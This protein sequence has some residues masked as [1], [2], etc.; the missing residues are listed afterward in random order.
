MAEADL[1]SDLLV[2][3]VDSVQTNKNIEAFYK[4]YEDKQGNIEEIEKRF[5]RIMS[6]I[7]SIYKADEIKNTNWSRIH[8][9][10]TLFTSLSNMVYG[11]KGLKPVTKKAINEKS[12]GK[13]R[14]ALDNLS[15]QYDM[16]ALDID[17]PEYPQDFKQFIYYSRRGTTDTAARVF[18][19]NF[20]CKKLKNIL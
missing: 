4:E 1:T 20:L 3:L 9:F 13:L 5:D 6:Y 11:I 8:L 16:I 17:S 10:Y 19:A 15:A 14:N 18:R 7:G 12:I 2:A